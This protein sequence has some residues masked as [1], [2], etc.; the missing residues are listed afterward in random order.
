MINDKRLS[1][2]FDVSV[3]MEGFMGST[4]DARYEDLTPKHTLF[5]KRRIY[6][7]KKPVED[8]GVKDGEIQ[9]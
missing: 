6:Q 2:R 4:G 8:L 9:K 5:E 1:K 7:G 3:L